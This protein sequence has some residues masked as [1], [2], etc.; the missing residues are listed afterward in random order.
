MTV[1]D[2][3]LWLR[4]SFRPGIDHHGRIVSRRSED[5]NFQIDRVFDHYESPQM[6]ELFSLNPS[7]EPLDQQNL[8]MPSF[9]KLINVS[10]DESERQFWSLCSILFDPLEDE[11]YIGETA[12]MEALNRWLIENINCCTL[13]ACI[14]SLPILSKLVLENNVDGAAQLAASSGAPRLAVM[15]SLAHADPLLRQSCFERQCLAWDPHTHRIPQEHWLI[16]C[17]LAGRI[18]PVIEWL[19]DSACDTHWLLIFALNFWF[20]LAG[21]PSERLNIA[22]NSVQSND[23]RLGLMKLFLQNHFVVYGGQL[24]LE[25]ILRPSHLSFLSGGTFEVCRIAWILSRKLGKPMHVLDVQLAEALEAIGQPQIALCLVHDLKEKTCIISRNFELFQDDS[26]YNQSSPEF[27]MAKSLWLKANNS[28]FCQQFTAFCDVKDWL[29]ASI[30][31]SREVG[32][33]LIIENSDDSFNSLYRYLSMIPVEVIESAD[34][35]K[36]PDIIVASVIYG[37]VS[38]KMAMSDHFNPQNES[39]TLAFQNIFDNIRSL[40]SCYLNSHLGAKVMVA[41]ISRHLMT[42]SKQLGMSAPFQS[43]PLG[44]DSR[45]NAALQLAHNLIK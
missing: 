10:V 2:P 21:R 41:E 3:V 17:L 16:L 26:C 35:Q 15:I 23:T 37:Y 5:L 25:Y 8:Q 12:R 30:I 6:L 45:I 20:S 29:E 33:S 44:S 11:S 13:P 28:D 19:Q 7:G 39:V 42:M 40:P 1:R 9:A 38:L 14:Q 18:E 43:L 24:E 27:L 31:L 4:Q 36:N 32:P 34:F 22:I